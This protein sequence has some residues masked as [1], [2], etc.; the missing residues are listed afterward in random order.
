MSDLTIA[1]VALMTSWVVSDLATDLQ[2]LDIN[3][4]TPEELRTIEG[5]GWK[6]AEHIVAFR[7][8]NGPF[9]RPEDLLLVK[10]I[11]PVSFD[12]CFDSIAI[13]NC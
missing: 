3:T 9:K 6:V 10:G 8:K 4:A 5:I 1:A 2:K 7:E 12:K 11:G 13:T